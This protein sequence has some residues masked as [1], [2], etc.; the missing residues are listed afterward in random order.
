MTEAD[1]A[2]DP[3]LGGTRAEDVDMAGDDADGGAEGD[4][5]LPDIEPEVPHRVTFLEYD[6]GTLIGP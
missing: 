4:T 6:A 5:G 1:A 3:S 2:L